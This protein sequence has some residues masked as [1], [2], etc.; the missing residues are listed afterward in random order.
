MISLKAT[1]LAAIAAGAI[2]CSDA[3]ALKDAPVSV[4]GKVLQGG[5]PVGNVVVWFHPLD[6]GHLQNLPV[7]TD[8]TFLG[9]LVSGNYAY[10][11]GKSPAPSSEAVLKKIDPKFYEPD[12]ERSISVDFG[13]EIILALD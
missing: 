9:E 13:K 8:G 10:Y 12:L 3:A 5:Q 1:V 7:S 4:S 11:V 2:G 6:N